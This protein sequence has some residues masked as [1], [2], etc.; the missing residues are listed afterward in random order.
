MR[1]STRLQQRGKN[2]TVLTERA[3]TALEEVVALYEQQSQETRDKGLRALVLLFMQ[4]NSFSGK[5]S[6][7]KIPRNTDYASLDIDAKSKASTHTPDLREFVVSKSY[8]F[9][10][11]PG[12]F[13]ISC[14]GPHPHAQSIV[15]PKPHATQRDLPA[16]RGLTRGIGALASLFGVSKT[17]LLV[18][19]L[20]W[21]H[22][23]MAVGRGAPGPNCST[24]VVLAP[25][26]PALNE[27]R[28][29]FFLLVYRKPRRP[30]T[31]NIGLL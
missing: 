15:E 27:G 7:A 5:G 8:V 17:I 30:I 6:Q 9:E 16:A 11:T 29:F 13:D 23:G 4:W 3:K 2:K 20:S 31:S 14:C 19:P 28:V 21:Q 22:D 24:C 26:P 10:Y 12:D 1:R 18:Y 25:H